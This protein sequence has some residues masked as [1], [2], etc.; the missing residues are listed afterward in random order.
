[1]ESLFHNMNRLTQPQRDKVREFRAFTE[2]TDENA[3][4]YL[5]KHKW[6]IERAADD[7]FADPPPPPPVAADINKIRCLFRNY[8]AGEKI[9]SGVGLEKL[10]KDLAVEPE[11][12]VLFIFAWKIKARS[13]GEFT[14]REWEEGLQDLQLDSIEAFRDR[15]PAFRAEITDKDSFSQFYRFI[16]DY[17]LQKEQHQK[18]LD[19]NWAIELWTIVLKDKFQN[20]PKWSTFLTEHFKKA[21]S[22]DTWDQLLEFVLRVNNDLNKYDPNGAW[23]VVLDEFV[24]YLKANP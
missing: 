15:L 8:T 4:Q 24:E 23:P 11:D 6:N 13:L 7:Y 18:T 19:L 14:Q 17:S 16:F 2:A 20:L 1:L 10:I 9:E 21:I 5:Q 12:I 22:R 3:I